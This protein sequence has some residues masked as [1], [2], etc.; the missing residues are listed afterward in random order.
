MSAK[1]AINKSTKIKNLNRSIEIKTSQGLGLSVRCLVNRQKA[2]GS[3]HE[4]LGSRHEAL[5]KSQKS[6][7]K[8]QKSK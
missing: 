8:S 4:A 7:V 6:K 3:R 1:N 5:V 2:L